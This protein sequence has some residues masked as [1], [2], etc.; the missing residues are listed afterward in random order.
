MSA[1]DYFLAVLFYST[2]RKLEQA[3]EE[4]FSKDFPD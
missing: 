4:D 1:Y 3:S 2:C